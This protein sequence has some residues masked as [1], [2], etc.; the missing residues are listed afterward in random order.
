MAVKFRDYYEILGVSRKASQEEIQR[1][2]RK[3]ARK[4]HPDVNKE[5]G[6]EEKFK[7]INEAYE[8]LKDPEKRAKYD[9]LGSHW[10]AGQDFRPP[11]GWD[12][13]FDFE[14]GPG[15]QEFFWSG[16]G[17]FS[18]FFEMLFGGQSFRRA[19]GAGRTRPG[20]AW[21]QPGAD[22]HA[23]LRIRLEDAFHGATKTISFEGMTTAIDGTVRP[24][25][26]TLEVKIPKG[27]LPGQK[28]RLAGQGF[29]GV[30]GGPAGDLY[31]E[32]EI[33]PHPLYRLE[34]RDLFVDLPVAP[35]EAALGAEVP[36]RTLGGTYALKIPAG[37][38]SG[39]K[40]R[41]RG[42]GMPNPRGAPGDLYAVLKIVVPKKLT[43]EEKTLFE[44]LKDISGF[45]PRA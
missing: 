33:E 13:H 12:V 40:L 45:D 35:W 26:K 5:A 19:Q 10:R 30:S 37:S 1:A 28:I 43:R 17:D 18:D 2:Y 15:Q 25:V 21:R 31:L 44:K 7:E 4:Y 16:S 14:G 22:R 36:V 34:G 24:E 32:V 23:T 9:Q 29:E 39:Q 11:P 8:V 3:L 41:L 38:Q 6:A 42:K 20:A 27:I